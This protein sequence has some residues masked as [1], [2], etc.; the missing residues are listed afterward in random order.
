MSDK[1]TLCVELTLTNAASHLA[2][3]RGLDETEAL[4]EFM[5]TKTCEVLLNIDSL[6]CHESKE[7]VLDMYH[8]EMAGDWERWERI[9]AFENMNYVLFIQVHIANLYRR[10]H[11]MSL[12]EFNELDKKTNFLDFIA[13]SYEPFHLTGDEC[14]LIEMGN[15]C[16]EILC[17]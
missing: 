13:I 8:A 11:N 3:E 5:K 7:C 12:A 4:R 16:K 10:Q 15:Y 17:A 2:K 9:M 6:L 1:N 14:I